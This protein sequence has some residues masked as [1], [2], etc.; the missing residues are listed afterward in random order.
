M[1]AAIGMTPPPRPLPM[2]RMSG[3][4]PDCSQANIVPVRPRQL[5]ISSKTSNVPFRSQLCRTRCQKYGG[6]ASTVVQR[7]GSATTAATSPCTSST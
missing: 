7:M 2:T 3:T 6:G 4:A 1:T 5:G